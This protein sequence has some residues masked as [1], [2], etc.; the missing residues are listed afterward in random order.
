[1]TTGRVRESG[2]ERFD[3]KAWLT[4]RIV[5]PFDFDYEEALELAELWT[6]RLGEVVVEILTA[7]PKARV[8]AAALFQTKAQKLVDGEVWTTGFGKSWRFSSTDVYAYW[9]HRGLKEKFGASQVRPETRRS[10]FYLYW[11]CSEASDKVWFARL[12]TRDEDEAGRV[13]SEEQGGTGTF[14]PHLAIEN[15]PLP[16]TG[17][18]C[19]EN[20]V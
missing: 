15:S 14:S 11:T 7:K 9:F 1:M 3:R 12:A 6:D 19:Q 16:D 5:P 13:P 18:G 2:E 8:G 17:G 20:H 4:T 10:V